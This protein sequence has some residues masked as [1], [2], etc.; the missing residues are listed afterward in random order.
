MP[1]FDLAPPSDF[2]GTRTRYQAGCR[3]DRC[4]IA[5]MAYYTAYAKGL[6]DG[7]VKADE[8]RAHL[9]SLKARKVGLRHAAKLAGVSKWT[10]LCIRRGRRRSIHRQTEAA[11]L[12][13]PLKTGL[14]ERATVSN[15]DSYQTRE[16]IRRLC[17]EGYE[18]A[19]LAQ[20][21]GRHVL[22]FVRTTAKNHSPRVT[23]KTWRKVKALYQRLLF[24]DDLEACG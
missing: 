16:K 23:V 15:T 20:R 5:A 6:I 19:W 2:H 24:D 14:H 18:P 10:L 12:G 11:I 17:E 8:A 7:W 22:G 3:C 1:L 13:V 4:R 21:L 9:E